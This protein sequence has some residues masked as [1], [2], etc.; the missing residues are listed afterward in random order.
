MR[1]RDP[2]FSS[3]SSS[4]RR[5]IFLHS[6]SANVFS[7]RHPSNDSISSL[8]PFS[9]SRASTLA[10]RRASSAAFLRASS[11]IPSCSS[12]LRLMASSLSL[13]LSSRSSALPCSSS[14]RS[15]PSRSCSSRSSALLLSASAATRHSSASAMASSSFRRKA[16]T[17]LVR[18]RDFSAIS[19]DVSVKA[20][21][22]VRAMSSFP[23]SSR[24]RFWRR[25]LSSSSTPMTA[26]V[27]APPTREE[28]SC[29][30]SSV[31]L[32]LRRPRDLDRWP[33]RLLPCLLTPLLLLPPPLLPPLLLLLLPFLPLDVDDESAECFF[34][35]RAGGC[36]RWRR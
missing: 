8:N 36:W 35:T 19:S 30:G 15:L 27:G 2:M 6:S 7:A 26:G 31:P 1:R 10:L 5:N 24:T 13:S 20:S 29:A 11:S 14:F 4:V 25:A 28:D 33:W 16:R 32:R 18:E 9:T 3:D 21:R 23:S 34:S 17:S 12:S 22:S